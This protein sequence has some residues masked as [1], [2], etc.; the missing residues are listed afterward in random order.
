MATAFATRI[1]NAF[2]IDQRQ[3]A[4]NQDL[5]HNI[6]EMSRQPPFPR[7]APPRMD[8]PPRDYQPYNGAPGRY[9]RDTRD[10]RNG[11]D[12]YRPRNDDYNRPRSPPP[13]MY[14]FRGASRYDDRPAYDD[15]RNPPRYED[16]APGTA[17]YDS[18]QPRDAPYA[19]TFQ[20]QAPPNMELRHPERRRSPPRPKHRQENTRNSRSNNHRSEQRGRNNFR[21]RG[22]LRLASEREFLKGN[23][24]PTPEL[25]PGM[26]ERGDAI[27]FK[28]VED[29]SDSDETDMSVSEDDLDEQQPRKRQ[30]IADG[31]NRPMWS[32]PDPY[33]ALPPVDESLRKKKDMVKMI[34]KARVA[35]EGKEKENVA[36]SDFISFNFDED[37]EEENEEEE[38]Y[39]EYEPPP[40]V[41]RPS[42][43]NGSVASLQSRITMASTGQKPNPPQATTRDDTKVANASLSN[44][45]SIQEA[46]RNGTSVGVKHT[47][48]DLTTDSPPLSRKPASAISASTKAF[49]IPASKSTLKS[50]SEVLGN[51]R[52]NDDK[53]KFNEAPRV[54]DMQKGKKAPVSGSI[55]RQW[56]ASTASNPTPWIEIDHSDTHQMGFWYVRYF[57]HMDLAE[58]KPGYIKKSWISTT[59]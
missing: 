26:D 50:T 20:Q 52:T 58:H 43:R 51:K 45:T 7:G 34:R 25:L 54:H 47:T 44:G 39:M 10:D 31:D 1:P 55:V 42:T 11:Y 30:A 28:A 22:G 32:N 56:Q 41:S 19:F 12:N 48:I 29:L 49:V 23:R 9:D 4:S 15:R 27:R 35:N 24:A 8:Y 59:S 3:V 33:T 5:I 36:A 6:I 53:I 38:D 13:P 16:R 18:Y 21:G 14:E 40:A 2:F 37:E 46:S 17:N 57:R